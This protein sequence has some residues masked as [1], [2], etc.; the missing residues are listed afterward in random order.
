NIPMIALDSIGAGTGMYVRYNEISGRLEF[1][2]ESAGY[3][4]GVCNEDS[5]IDTVTITDCSLILGYLN[6]D[7]FLGGKIKLNKKRAYEFIEE[8]LAK[9]F[10]ADPY[11]AARGAIDLV[12]IHMRNHL[13]A[14][15][16]G[17]GFRPENYT[18]ISFGGGGPL[19]VAGYSKELNFENILI[20][21]WAAAFSA[22]GCAC[23]EHS[24]RYE[25]TIDGVITPDGRLNHAVSMVLNATWSDLKKKIIKEFKKEGR[26][27]NQMIF[28]PTVRIQYLGMLDDLEVESPS[29]NLTPDDIWKITKAY[30]D[31]FEDIYR[32]GTKSPELGY[33]ITKVVA[34]GIIDVPK[35]KLPEFEML[36]EEPEEKA[37]K[38]TR[39][40]Y[41]SGKW[42]EAALWEMEFLNSGNVIIGP[43]VIE[44]PATTLLVPPGYK[45]NLDK[46]RVFHMEVM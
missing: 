30:D 3:K 24:Y 5:G 22:F 44:A 1:G 15:I 20:P 37:S 6:P 17:L 7:Y 16:Q 8:Q 9:P 35:P 39:E 36:D 11:E 28:K 10:K 45:V 46:H 12:E 26:D 42:H 38:G 40:I 2:P 33:H 21:E 13:N 34:T 27:P 14:M 23:A 31:L 25:K 43:A 4:I 18:L 41:W 32:R 19:H 29:D